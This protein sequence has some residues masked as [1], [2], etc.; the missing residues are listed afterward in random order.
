MTANEAIKRI[1]EHTSVH[2]RKEPHAVHITEALQLACTALEKQIPKKV[3]P[4]PYFYGQELHCPSCDYLIGWEYERDKGY[5][6]KCGQALD[7]SDAE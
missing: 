2:L 5:C 3:I 1:R 4:Q 6:R 7:W